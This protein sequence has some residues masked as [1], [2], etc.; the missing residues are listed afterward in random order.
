MYYLCSKNKSAVQLCGYRAID[1]RLCFSHMQKAGF[2][3]TGLKWSIACKQEVHY[4]YMIIMLLF[5]EYFKFIPKRV[6]ALFYKYFMTPFVTVGTKEKIIF[7][8]S[9]K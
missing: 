6:H 8:V 5:H 1:L 2:L 9:I 7:A 3:K 4:N